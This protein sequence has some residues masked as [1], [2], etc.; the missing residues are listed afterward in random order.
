MILFSIIF[1]VTATIIFWLGLNI[2]S[3][4]NYEATFLVSQVALYTTIPLFPA[5]VIQRYKT[6]FFTD[7]SNQTKYAV[8][9][10]LMT[11]I[12]GMVNLYVYQD[13]ILIS[14][15]DPLVRRLYQLLSFSYIPF[16]QIGGW[17]YQSLMVFFIAVIFGTKVSF[18]KYLNFVGISYVGFLISTFLSLVL[19]ILIV[20]VSLIEENILIRYTVGKFGEALMLILLVFFIYYNEEQF[21]LIKSCLI[22]CLPT[23]IIILFQILL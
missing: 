1:S 13:H 9:I 16:S 10:V 7:L 4:V 12:I 21:G 3:Q 18:K 8:Y 17:L 15:E 6:R 19:N 23:V 20:D 14:L 11:V 5:E 22:A 2:F